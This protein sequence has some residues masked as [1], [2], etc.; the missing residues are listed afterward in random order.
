MKKV[1]QPALMRGR[2][3]ERAAVALLFGLLAVLLVAVVVGVQ[4]LG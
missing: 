3:A 2:V 4:S 1:L